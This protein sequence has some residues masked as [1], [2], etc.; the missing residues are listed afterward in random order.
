MRGSSKVAAWFAVPIACTAMIGAMAFPASATTALRPPGRPAVPVRH[1][2]QTS[3]PSHRV[4][5]PHAGSSGYVPSMTWTASGTI[6]THTYTNAIEAI[7]CV[8][9]TFCMAVGNDGTALTFNGT[10]WSSPMLVDTHLE[11]YPYNGNYPLISVSCASSAFCMAGDLLGRSYVYSSGT[12][13]SL[14][15]PFPWSLYVSCVSATDCFGVSQT[16]AANYNGTSWGPIQSLNSSSPA[17]EALSCLPSGTSTFCLALDTDGNAYEYSNGAWG[18]PVNVAPQFDANS[19]S[20]A[21]STYCLAVS[22]SSVYTFSGGTWTA[23]AQQSNMTLLQAASCAPGTQACSWTNEDNSS[24]QYNGS[25]GGTAASGVSLFPADWWRATPMP[26]SCPSATFCV[27][28]DDYGGVYT[29]SSSTGWDTTLD[30]VDQTTYGGSEDWIS[31]ASSTFCMVVDSEG[32]ATAFVNGVWQPSQFID[33][34]QAPNEAPD[35]GLSLTSVSCPT[36]Q[37]CL[38]AD[39]S[40]NVF[41]FNGSRWSFVE[42]PS[43]CSY[44][45]NPCGK[46][47]DG[48]IANYLVSCG[49]ATS[50]LVSPSGQTTYMYEQGKL[51]TVTAPITPTSVWCAS[52]TSCVMVDGSLT[53]TIYNGTSWSG[54]ITG[55]LTGGS[56]ESLSCP[57]TTW[58][59][60]FG[61]GTSTTSTEEAITQTSSGPLVA[62]T[63]SG[64][65]LNGANVS[66]A[67]PQFCAVAAGFGQ[68]VWLWNGSA[69][70]SGSNVE[71]SFSTEYGLQEISCPTTGF[72]MAI[73][74]GSRAIEGTGSILE[75][76]A[77]TRAGQA[78]G[79]NQSEACSLCQQ[80]A[81]PA[82][83]ST[84]RPVN[85]ATGDEY[86]T[87]TD[88]TAA[89]ASQPLALTRTYSSALGQ[90]QAQN[91]LSPGPLGYGWSCNLCMT[92]RTESNGDAVVTNENGS[93]TTFA[94]YVAGSSPTWCIASYDFCPTAPRVIATLN[95]NVDGTWIYSRDVKGETAFSFDANGMLDGVSN[96]SGASI[97]ESSS[98]PGVNGCPTTA[99]SCSAWTASPSGH[100]LTLAYNSLGQL[101]QA[102]DDAGASA[103]YGF[104]PEQALSSEC[105]S[106]ASETTDNLS[107]VTEPNGQVTSYNYDGGDA[108][109]CFVNDLLSEDLPGGGVVSNTYNTSTSEANDAWYGW[110]GSQTDPNGVLTS[111]S[112]DG[113]NLSDTGGTTTV[114][115][116]SSSTVYSY[117]DGAVTS[118]ET[119]VGT[120]SEESAAY[121]RDPASALAAVVIDGNGNRTSNTFSNAGPLA[122]A[123]IT[124]STDAL[125]NTTQYASTTNN[126]V[127]CVVDPVDFANGVTCPTSAPT[128]PTAAGTD[129]G[130]IINVY[131]PEDEPTSTTNADG[132]TTVYGYVASGPDAGLN[133]CTISPVAY[134]A[135][136]TSCPAYGST[137]SG[138][139]TQT[140][141][142]FGN[143][144]TST[145]A[146]GNTTESAYTSLNK[147]W[148]TVDAAD[149]LNGTRCPATMPASPPPAGTDL[150]MTINVYNS[151]DEMTS[152]TDPLGN[153]TVYGYTGTSSSVPEGLVY[154]TLSPEAVDRS[155]TCPPYGATAPD[156]RSTTYDAGGQ[157]T[158]ETN[159]FGLTTTTCYYFEDQLGQ[160]AASAPP[161]GDG[162]D[163]SRTYATTDPSGDVTSYSYDGAGQVL[164]STVTFNAYVATTEY[165]YDA[166]GQKYCTVTPANYANGVNCPPPP[167][168]LTTPIAASGGDPYVGATID[169][170]DDAGNLVQVTDPTGAVTLYAYD[171]DGRQYCTVSPFF[172]TPGEAGTSGTTCPTT[173]PASPPT[174][175]SDPYA[176]AE[177]TTYDAAGNVIQSTSATGGITAYTYDAN[178]SKASKTVESNNTTADPNIVTDYSYDSANQLVATTVA[179]GTSLAATTKQYYDPNGDVYCT[180]APNAA[181]SGSSY[182]GT[183]PSWQ[184]AWIATPPSPSSLYPT[185]ANNVT[186][187][188]ANANGEVVQTTNP[189][190]DTSVTEYDPN[191]RVFCSIDPVNV[192]NGVTCPAWGPSLAPPQGV[193]T[194]YTETIYT[195]GG[196]LLGSV[197]NPLGDMTS[198]EYDSAGNNEA[199]VNPDGKSTSYCYY[200]EACAPKGAGGA[201]N[202]VYSTTLPATAADPNG[203]V[204]YKA[205]YPGGRVS[206][207][208]TPSGD[209]VFGYDQAGNL[210]AKTYLYSASGYTAPL[211][212]VYTYYP[213]GIR[214]SMQDW[215]QKTST[216]Q[217]IPYSTT[218]YGVPNTE[219]GLTSAVTYTP[220]TGSSLSSETVVYGYSS[221]GVL[222]GMQYPPT[223]S[224]SQPRV[225]YAYNAAGEMT[226]V[227]DWAGNEVTFGYDLNGNVTAQDDGVS[228]TNPNGTSSTA[229]SYDAASYMTQAVSQLNAT[230]TAISPEIAG[231]TKHRSGPGVPAS[232]QG[233]PTWNAMQHFFNPTGTGTGSATAN[234]AG[235]P[236]PPPPAATSSQAKS[237]GGI[238]GTGA[239]GSAKKTS[240]KRRT[241]AGKKGTARQAKSR[242]PKGSRKPHTT[243]TPT[244]ATM[245]QS[246]QPSAG[247][248]RNADGQV[249]QDA[250][251][252]QD[253]CGNVLYGQ[254][255][256]SYDQAGQVVFQGP[257]PQG[258]SANNFA[259]DPAGCMMESSSHD[260][261]GNFNTYNQTVDA[262][263][264]V[265]AQ[266]ALPGGTG[267]GT[268]TY[269]TLGDRTQEVSGSTTLAFG[270]N[271]IG[272]MTSFTN[273]SS[274]TRYL[275]DGDGNEE[276]II[277]PGAA[278]PTQ[279]VWNTT[280]SLPLLLSDG[281]DYYIY[282]PSQTPVEQVDVTSTPPTSN[283]TFMTYASPDDAWI[284]TDLAGQATNFWRYDA[285]GNISNGS[286]GSAFGYA[287]QYEDVSSNSSGLVNMRA[288]WYD[289]QTGNFT[290]VDPALASTDQP[291][292]YATD[293]PVNQ[294]DPTGL[295]ACVSYEPW[296]YGGCALNAIDN[297]IGS[298]VRPLIQQA[299]SELS[300]DVVI[301]P[302][303]GGG[304]GSGITLTSAIDVADL[305]QG[306]SSRGGDWITNPDWVGVD[307]SGTWL[308]PLAPFFPPLAVL[309][310][311]GQ[312][313]VDRYGDAYIGPQVGISVP[314]ALAVADAGWVW[315]STIPSHSYLNTFI[316]GF[317]VSGQVAA[318][319][320]I[321]VS[322]SII[323]GN[324]G[325]WGTS[326]FGFQVGI[327]YA[328]GHTASAQ[329]SWMFGIGGIGVK[330]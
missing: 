185:L 288:R 256:Y 46:Q 247:Y 16:G 76:G 24:D 248:H 215:S 217:I 204:T 45:T 127:Y 221:T 63:H 3:L 73:D 35:L 110:V 44:F 33:A 299:K 10:N 282:G 223:S 112:Y 119:G 98:A 145:D 274:T 167:P 9:T 296:T 194:G 84:K 125:G 230:A 280:A 314:G 216:N 86:E 170:Y 224:V 108:N 137:E 79:R 36:A 141:D 121:E 75:G 308:A 129:L 329:A 166:A 29:W 53:G 80:G 87:T 51:E 250:E 188:L 77:M 149:Y 304:C 31:C 246:F 69:W 298:E 173:P 283:P 259:Y 5:R 243:C 169:T 117:T 187:S 232:S 55:F 11:S 151:D 88:L 4:M 13:S 102:T 269:D 30:T 306:A 85:T 143:V 59:M 61:G 152:S 107:S 254:R 305:S 172:A 70:S 164:T 266:T 47:S 39:A 252:Y 50:C 236:L 200:E 233:N 65:P 192:A 22:G 201:G 191:G 139:A 321:A 309:S 111:F 238:A 322:G 249:T 95:Q 281:I 74:L 318:A 122:A 6:D 128:A 210:I 327:G 38:A 92:V 20:C 263:C 275:Y 37:F 147:V 40:G 159:G 49:S 285:Y 171:A 58:C 197:T 138:V 150:G 99:T 163:T 214:S 43:S 19:L 177:I 146:D 130:M 94:P 71:G 144:V 268:Y 96:A 320:G 272:Q 242:Q 219:D 89:T 60:T 25:V 93:Q 261:S 225:M 319:A 8:S 81:P 270:Y 57:T 100:W 193:V 220:G 195:Y 199:V 231:R 273:G 115:S 113:D 260:G 312:L 2:P 207:E 67:T 168:M 158:S 291:Y 183:C 126:E 1:T 148:C 132:D 142:S 239:K 56:D 277:P 302:A 179:S 212:V 262:N 234:G 124:T 241:V 135:G 83:V 324:A 91:Q 297:A 326:A 157:V 198:Y 134:A 34:Y 240:T 52:G 271:Q 7:S 286:A 104:Y 313:V 328:G 109:G 184:A 27:V 123:Q 300:G 290:T 181:A 222:L 153:T 293:N 90:D 41:G 72:C 190:V 176:G 323:Y 208:G 211:N 229:F 245:T 133:Y 32:D 66:C 279:F 203:A 120:T 106:G 136:T 213:G 160:C 196:G 205:Y 278:S 154:C 186:T 21:S 26:I 251:T 307:V 303:S 78:G 287:G 289:S 182:P 82:E 228:A 315:E 276:A 161:G 178:G 62:F 255:N 101:V 103:Y 295:H 23:G 253:N 105:V 284:V 155:I 264:E 226:S 258:T 156:A 18:P 237:R 140:F 54:G 189:D 97:G 218:I 162:G 257:N 330:W 116:G 64:A 267:G 325:H 118:V 294:T 17:F 174:P 14:S 28:G 235:P 317:S 316:S 301:A 175:S 68:N 180:I 165:A 15:S 206:L 265:T 114:S 292:A 48:Y 42:N 131:N 209:T 244:T 310:L 202:M 12:W 227:T 311:G